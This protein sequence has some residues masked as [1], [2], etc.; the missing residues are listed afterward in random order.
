MCRIGIMGGTF[1]PIHIG[2]LL[3]AEW[4]V[5][6]ADLDEVWIIP[7]GV[8][9]QKSGDNI[10]PGAERLHMVQLA[11]EG[12]PKMQSL[13]LEIKREGYTYTYETLEELKALHPD[14]QYFFI[15]GA[16]CLFSL[17]SWKEPEKI[18][19]N[20]TLIAALRNDMSMEKM[21]EKKRELIRRF[22]GDIILFPFIRMSI[23][24]SEIRKRVS[25]GKS[26][27]YMVP[28]SVKNY[29]D[30]KGFYRG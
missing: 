21:I 28:D 29:I 20:S 25:E 9:Y 30:E 26:I 4:A 23:S 2:H 1:N 10:L 7:A 12:N 16:D 22:G 17:E 14:N 19:R 13:D 6:N 18:F 11:I 3:L 15:M 8:P 27:R 24:S 5:E